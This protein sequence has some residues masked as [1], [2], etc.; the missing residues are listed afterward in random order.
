MKILFVASRYPF[1]PFQGDRAR[2]Y[3]QIGH[4][5]QR[6]RITLLAPKPSGG[7]T[8]TGEFLRR[9][10]ERIELVPFSWPRGFLRLTK[11][12]FF[13]LP[14]QTLF[15]FDP[16]IRRRIRELLAKG[17]YDLIH[18]QL[19]RMG[20]AAV[21]ISRTP[22]VLD[23]IDALS[24]NWF[25]RAEREVRPV[26]GLVR[27][28]AHRLQKYEREL[29]DEY[30]HLVVSSSVDQGAIG[31][32]KNLHIVANGV[33][34]E[35]FPF[36]EDG[37]E[38][39]TI[40]LSGR[41]GY[42][43][44]ADAANWFAKEVFPL[45][46]RE[47]PGA[48]FLIVGADPP[49][50]IKALESLPGVEVTGR[51]PSLQSYLMRAAVA[52]CPLRTGSGMQFKV[53]EAMASGTPVVATP[54]ALGGIEAADEEHLLIARDAGDF[55][56]QV[57]RLLKDSVLQRRLASKARQLV[58]EMYTWERSVG[59]LEDVYESAVQSRGQ[60]GEWQSDFPVKGVRQRF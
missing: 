19:A 38:H 26:A 52:V 10:C 60:K 28:E 35:D 44:N 9:M 31:Q 57:V 37:R 48:R 45:I 29:V 5:S 59:I 47:V 56:E 25:R 33:E 54:Y 36:V 4:L 27:W 17:D 55:A 41:M 2:A 40:I 24:L 11:A 13:S 16:R 39:G 49:R 20:P 30:D 42:F 23:L 22:R 15:F 43:P 32:Y 8:G 46:R 58:E 18:V 51:V 6:H 7:E 50:R 3:H 53:L 14:C 21:G 34:L 12:P 1:P